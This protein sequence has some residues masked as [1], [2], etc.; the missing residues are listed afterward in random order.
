MK[1]LYLIATGAAKNPSGE[2]EIWQALRAEGMDVR[3]IHELPRIALHDVA[4]ADPVV[5]RLVKKRFDKTEKQL[6][7]ICLVSSEEVLARRLAGFPR[8]YIEKMGRELMDLA[9]DE[10]DCCVPSDEPEVAA[11]LLTDLIR[12]RESGC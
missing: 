4:V 7:L 3:D 12:S 11:R 8:D 10:A 5:A 2:E 1:G 9:M 6:T